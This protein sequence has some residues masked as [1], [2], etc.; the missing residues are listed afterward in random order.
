MTV[1]AARLRRRCDRL[2]DSG[3][4]SAARDGSPAQRLQPAAM[5]SAAPQR[6]RA[7]QRAM[8]R[9]RRGY[10]RGT[11]VTSRAVDPS[12][13]TRSIEIRPAAMRRLRRVRRPAP[14]RPRA[15]RRAAARLSARPRLSKRRRRRMQ[16]RAVGGKQRGRFV[17]SGQQTLR[18]LLEREMRACFFVGDHQDGG[19]P[20]VSRD[21]RAAAHHRAAHAS[22]ETAQPFEPRRS[23]MRQRAGEARDL[24]RRRALGI[25]GVAGQSGGRCALKIA[26]AAGLPQ[27]IRVASAL[28]SHTGMSPVA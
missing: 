20:S 22:A 1:I 27:R 18:L 25:D 17:V 3:R 7:R 4:G 28:H 26:A 5:R 11:K 12:A 21:A 13:P 8:A 10:S 6:V 16:Q 15:R 23:A 14:W 19:R 2:L 24:Q 9:R